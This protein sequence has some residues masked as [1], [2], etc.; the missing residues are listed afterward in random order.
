MKARHLPWLLIAAGLISIGLAIRQW[1]HFFSAIAADMRVSLDGAWHCLYTLPHACQFG[2]GVTHFEGIELYQPWLFWSGAAM[3][4]A[5][6][7]AA[8]ALL[9]VRR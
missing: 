8:L 2:Q 7:L 4:V 5:G 3:A 6:A 9:V 1:Y